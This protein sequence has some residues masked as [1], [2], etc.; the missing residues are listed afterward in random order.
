[1]PEEKPSLSRVPRLSV[2]RLLLT[3]SVALAVVLVCAA[4]AIFILYGPTL[5]CVRAA[6]GPVE[7][8]TS[9]R[10]VVS[11]GRERCTL[12]HVPP[13]Y[14][15]AQPWPLVIS[16]HGFQS[17]PELHRLL[18]RWDDL[19]DQHGFLVA[20][21]QGSSFP[22][23][24]NTSAHSNISKVDD[25]QFIADLIAHV[26]EISTVD[27]TRVY[28][29]GFSNGGQMAHRIACELADTVTAAG[30]VAGWGAVLAEGCQ[31]S[32]PVPIMAFF[33]NADRQGNVAG[34]TS[35][36]SGLMARLFNVR[37]GTREYPSLDAWIKG[38]AERNGCDVGA[39]LL[40]SRGDAKGIAFTDCDDG[41]DVVLYTVDGGGHTWPGGPALPFNGKTSHDID[42]SA[43]MWAF[44]ER[45]SLQPDP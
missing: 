21:P 39:K 34:G 45:F 8:G 10:R 18:T 7:P 15:A 17:K 30:I 35:H 27:S 41:A 6:T 19:A 38:W 36:V 9:G 31:P 1:M 16:L 20:Y 12:L 28:V 3:A 26:G 37:P 13:D 23:R 11:G 5:A 14:D 32:R 29:A 44:F 33:G 22:L 4:A 24:W 2:R 43:V 42:A 25:V 40:P